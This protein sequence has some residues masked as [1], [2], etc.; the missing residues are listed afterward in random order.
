VELALPLAAS[1][2][3]A[4]EASMDRRHHPGPR[5]LR[6]LVVAVTLALVPTLVSPVPRGLA[7]VDP[8]RTRERDDRL[9]LR[10]A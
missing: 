9:L 3:V 8:M 5:S 10:R 6:T 1:D 7:M 4:Q 2:L